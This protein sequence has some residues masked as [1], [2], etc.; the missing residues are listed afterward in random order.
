MTLKSAYTIYLKKSSRTGIVWMGLFLQLLSI[1]FFMNELWVT[2]QL[3]MLC[4]GPIIIAL[5]IGILKLKY[6][7]SNHRVFILDYLLI[8]AT[9]FAMPEFKFMGIL[10]LVLA[11]FDRKQFQQ[12]TVEIGDR[13]QFKNNLTK[14]EVNWN[15]LENVV[16]KAG[17]LTLDFKNNKLLQLD[18]D[19]NKTSVTEQEFN[20]FCQNKL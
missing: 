8:A 20:Q 15:E 1:P 12:Q 19:R 6:K 10:F 5:L 7:N 9:W 11:W 16:L 18:I 2:Q 17:I 13:I 3:P 4:A 14:K